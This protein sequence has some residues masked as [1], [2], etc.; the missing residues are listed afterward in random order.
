MV[1]GDG[2]VATVR[3][4]VCWYGCGCGGQLSWADYYEPSAGIMQ[5]CC[6]SMTARP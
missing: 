5:Q 1:L 3:A 6:Q 4:G 2:L